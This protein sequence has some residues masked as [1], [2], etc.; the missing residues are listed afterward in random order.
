MAARLSGS[1]DSGG[2]RVLSGP[3]AELTFWTGKTTIRPGLVTGGMGPGSEDPA[4]CV[5]DGCQVLRKCLLWHVVH[6]HGETCQVRDRRAT[7]SA[8][9]RVDFLHIF[10]PKGNFEDKSY[11]L[12]CPHRATKT[13]GNKSYFLPCPDTTTKTRGNKSYFLPCPYTTT[14]TRGN[15]S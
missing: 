3:S 14:K 2:S 15:K 13:R 6:L 5:G 9:V 8:A 12:P 4:S 1:G 7:K 10:A 11:F